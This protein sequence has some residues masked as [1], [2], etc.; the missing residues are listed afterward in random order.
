[1]S[2]PL[3]GIPS[4]SA[5]ASDKKLMAEASRHSVSTDIGKIRMSDTILPD[6]SFEMIQC[7]SHHPLRR[8]LFKFSEIYRCCL[9]SFESL[10]AVDSANVQPSSVPP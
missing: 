5:S 6:L 4:R 8:E 7:R 1:M 9:A 10:V 3:D 2:R